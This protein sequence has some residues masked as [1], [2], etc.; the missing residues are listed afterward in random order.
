MQCREI[1]KRE[2]GDLERK[3]GRKREGGLLVP[4]DIRQER[5][6]L[7]EVDMIFAVI[8]NTRI[9]KFNPYFSMEPAQYIYIM[10]IC[11]RTNI[12]LR[13]NI[14]ILNP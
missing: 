14:Y 5:R 10:Y 4:A 12:Y 7:L 9:I 8:S 11:I 6:I 3:R 13:T 2:S 1:V